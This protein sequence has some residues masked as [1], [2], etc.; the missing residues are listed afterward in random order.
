MHQA[1]AM[2]CSVLRDAKEKT[3]MDTTVL[4]TYRF[5]SSLNDPNLM[6]A[7]IISRYQTHA[8]GYELNVVDAFMQLAG[9]TGTP[10]S[11]HCNNRCDQ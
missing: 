6:V 5:I 10:A 1:E 4:T 7:T 9:Q 3:S 2:N 8:S 11:L